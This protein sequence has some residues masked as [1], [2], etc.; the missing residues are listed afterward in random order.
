MP[1]GDRLG[2]QA[3]RDGRYKAAPIWELPPQKLLV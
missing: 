2:R 3:D 1:C